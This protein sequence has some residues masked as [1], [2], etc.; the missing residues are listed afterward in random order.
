[1]IPSAITF[2][3]QLPMTQNGKI[4]RKHLLESSTAESSVYRTVPA[5][6]KEKMIA[7]IWAAILETETPEI[8]R[9][10]FDIGVDS[11]K[12]IQF[13]TEIK[14]RGYEISLMDIYSNDTIEKLAEAMKESGDE[15]TEEDGEIFED[16]VL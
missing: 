11:L 15:F 6:D 9:S 1:M 14:N 10:L 12:A 3:P 4:D 16:G 8:D 5:N 13:I 7:D 2:M